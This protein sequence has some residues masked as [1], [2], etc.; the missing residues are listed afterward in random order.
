[1]SGIYSAPSMPGGKVLQLH[2]S[3]FY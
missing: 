1:M 2:M 3:W